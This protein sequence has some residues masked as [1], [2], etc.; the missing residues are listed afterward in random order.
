MAAF[1][2]DITSRYQDD[3]AS[4]QVLEITIQNRIVLT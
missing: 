1:T 2:K 4:R 3:L